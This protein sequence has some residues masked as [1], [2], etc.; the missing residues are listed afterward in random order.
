MEQISPS[1]PRCG[2][3]NCAPV[4]DAVRPKSYFPSG[5]FVTAMETYRCECGL[6]FTF[7]KPTRP[8]NAQAA[9]QIDDGRR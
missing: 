6:S 8:A 4:A 5:F 1:C 7:T 2:R 9:E 3:T